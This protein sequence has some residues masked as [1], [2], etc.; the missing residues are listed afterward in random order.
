V[1]LASTNP[2]GR[3]MLS[4]LVFEA[5][6]FGLAIAGMIQ[7]SALSV[8][9]SFGLGLGAAVLAIV[10][11]ALLRCPGGYLLG[12]LTQAVAVGL[13]FAT[14]MMFAVGGIFLLLWVVCFVLGRRIETTPPGGGR[15]A[16]PA[17]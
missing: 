6:I 4:I 16:P 7:V 9:L 8:Q 2:M 1:K 5:I 14:P 12:W 10:A 11:A 17:A 15:P 3:V 13:G